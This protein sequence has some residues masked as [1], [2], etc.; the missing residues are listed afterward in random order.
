MR[1]RVRVRVFVLVCRIGKISEL[2]ARSSHPHQ[3]VYVTC[4][5]TH[6]RGDLIEKHVKIALQWYCK[7][8]CVVSVTKTFTP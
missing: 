3:R 1:A 6:R 8:Y 7:C 4:D 2:S 5:P